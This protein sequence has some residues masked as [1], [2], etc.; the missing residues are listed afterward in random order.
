[1]Q[2]NLK[3]VFMG[4]KDK[5]VTITV[6]N[7]KDSITAAEIKTAM[8]TILTSN[9]FKTTGGEITS[10]KSASV[11]STDTEAVSLS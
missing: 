5:A 4:A 3:M 10:I 11:V 8:K 6:Q 2:K 9:I 1:M 7:V